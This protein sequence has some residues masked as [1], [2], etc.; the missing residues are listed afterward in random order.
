METVKITTSQNIEIDYAV[1]TLSDRIK[2]RMIDYLVF[3]GLYTVCAMVFFGDGEADA[4]D[5]KGFIV[6]I[7]VWLSLCVFYDLATEVF[8]NGQS[9]GKRVAKIKVV[10]LNGARPTV[11]Q[12]LLRWLFRILDF[13]ISFGSL[14][15]VMVAWTDKKQRL[16]DIVAGTAV[17]QT[18]PMQQFGKLFFD[19][20]EEDYVVTYTQ[21]S[22]L[23]DKDIHLVY[24]VIRNFN[25]TR[26]SNLVYKLA[27]RIKAHLGVIY[28][29]EINE[30]QFLE[31]IVSD[32]THLTGRV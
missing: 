32:Y 25:Y 16:G 24:D 26:N 1:A 30:Y 7:V 5:N 10:S 13:G 29:R 6:I 2:G 18:Q 11:G 22:Q 12:Y 27:L 15:M 4:G 23:T 14:A 20:P 17:V 3:L 21:A 28:P 8:F 19:T 31:L 9:I